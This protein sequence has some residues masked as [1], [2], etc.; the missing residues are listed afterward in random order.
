[1]FVCL[2]IQSHTP[3]SQVVAAATRL[4]AG[5]AHPALQLVGCD[6]EVTKAIEYTFGTTFICKVCWEADLATGL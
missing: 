1:M 3:S 5:K 2:Q 4:G 6:A